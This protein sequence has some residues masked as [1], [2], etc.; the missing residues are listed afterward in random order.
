MLRT[1]YGRSCKPMFAIFTLGAG[2][3]HT[4]C[5]YQYKVVYPH[6]FYA[7]REWTGSGARRGELPPRGTTPFLATS[8]LPWVPRNPECNISQLCFFPRPQALAEER[9]PP[10]GL[11][12]RHL[13]ASTLSATPCQLSTAF[14]RLKRLCP[15][16]APGVTG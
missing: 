6:N 13:R 11:E 7:L 10:Q 3:S 12:P 9:H 4:L 2:H 16:N 5:T 8:P 1:Y 15:G 14:L